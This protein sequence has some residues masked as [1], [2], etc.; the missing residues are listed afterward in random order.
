LELISVHFPKAAGSSLAGAL[1]SQFGDALALDYHH[2]PVNPDHPLSERPALAEGARAVHG[3][4]RW[5]RYIEHRNAFRLTF[6]RDPV[7][8]LTPTYTYWPSLPS[9]GTPTHDRFL[10][11]QPSILDFAR[12]YWPLR[13]LMSVTYFGGT[14]IK[15]FDFVGFYETRVRDLDRLSKQL[16]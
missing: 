3:H 14:D 1:R 9:Q 6:L 15:S 10:S 4:F 7:A 13:R 2:D 5:D 16:G 12:S 11:E 8:D